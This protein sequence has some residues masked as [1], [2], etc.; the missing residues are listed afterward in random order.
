[1]GCI[2]S[3][4]DK[5]SSLK[6]RT[7]N[8]PESITPH[9]SNY[10]SDSAQTNQSP[11]IKGPSANFNSHSVTP[12]GGPSGMTPFGGA[13]SFSSVP[14]PYPSGLTSKLHFIKKVVL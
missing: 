8:A 7:E 4:E 9:G 6:Y 3:K 2:K 12:F 1:M 11:A 5:G 14:C 10:G 13:S